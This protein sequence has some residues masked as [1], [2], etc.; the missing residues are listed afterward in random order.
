MLSGHVFDVLSAIA[1]RVRNNDIPFGGIQL[2]LC[3]DFLQL[4]PVGINSQKKVDIPRTFCFETDTWKYIFGDYANPDAMR[5]SNGTMILLD[6]IFRQRDNIF[7][8]IL[9]EV[10]INKLTPMS[11][12][13][14]NRKSMASAQ[15]SS[16]SSSTS[17][18][19]FLC[20]QHTKLYAT[21]KD[22]NQYN[23]NELESCFRMI[24]I[25]FYQLMRQGSPPRFSRQ[26]IKV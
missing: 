19:S 6:R 5:G 7:L 8:Q 24:M 9:N 11:I 13:V 17:S 26:P 12:D 18:S 21:N 10:R 20:I 15:A 4:P 23:N 25:R 14:L 22:V 2:L 3:G 16:S 1:C